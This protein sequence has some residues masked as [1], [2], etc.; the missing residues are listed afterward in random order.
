MKRI[1]ETYGEKILEIHGISDRDLDITTFPKKFYVN[2][3]SVASISVDDNANVN[4]KTVTQYTHE[5]YK[6]SSK[7]GSLYLLYKWIKKT[8][9]KKDAEKAVENIVSGKIFVNDFHEIDKSYCYAFDLREMIEYGLNFYKPKSIKPPKR[10]DSF[11]NLVIQATAYISNQITGAVSYPSLFP[12]LDWFY[13]REYGE[14]YISYIRDFKDM[15]VKSVDLDNVTAMEY[16]KIAC[17]KNIKEQ[18]QTFIYSLN[19]NSFRAG[20]QTPFTNLSVL[21][22]GYLKHLFEGY[23]L[24]DNTLPNIEST[25]ELSKIF[26]EYFNSIQCKENV[27]TF[28]VMTLAVSLDKETNEYLDPEFKDWISE[29]NSDKSVGN[30]F[31]SEPTKFSSCCRLIN[32]YNAFEDSGYQNSFGVGGLSIG[33]LRVS[34]INMARLAISEKENENEL[35]D[36]LECVH[37]ILYA[38]RK[39]IKHRIS[40]GVMPLYTNNWININ[41]Q[42]STVGLIACNEYLE[43]KGLDILKEDGQNLLLS[44]FST[45]SETA[46]KWT[47]DEGAEHCVYNIE[48]IPG[49]SQAVKL[50]DIDRCLGLNKKYKLYSNQY[51]PLIKDASIYDRTRVQGVYDKL[52]S[53]GSILHITHKEKE[54]LT[55]EQYKALIELN[56]KLGV[57]YFAVNYSYSICDKNHQLI[58]DFDICPICGSDKITKYSRVAGFITPVESWN[59]IRK[60][61]E[62]DRRVSYS[63]EQFNNYENS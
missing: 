29:V 60:N 52:S 18:L 9:T 19:F 1:K 34:G 31:Q 16:K 35:Q 21:D 38:H 32:D 6:A 23:Y 58:G 3:G 46:K 63:T 15:D 61:Y 13:R 30:V 57:S 51:V 37:K 53:G 56:K 14:D 59:K 42:F 2:S 44:K 40:L 49:E 10:S 25:Y 24:P 39:L 27:F 12:I 50:A 47:M 33:S 11:L 41:K 43:N 55:K 7:L 22:R 20:G 62:Y 45:I 28:P 5:R 17:W 8:F 36:L 4:E 54:P 26:F 48:V